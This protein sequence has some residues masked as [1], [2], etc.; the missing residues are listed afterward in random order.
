MSVMMSLDWVHGQSPDF[1]L[2]LCRG[3]EEPVV[4]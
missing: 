2:S 3:K 4:G 1:G